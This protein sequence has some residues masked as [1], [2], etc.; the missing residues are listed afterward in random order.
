MYVRRIEE[1]TMTPAFAK[2]QID[3]FEAI[4]A[5]YEK[6]CEGERLL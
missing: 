3:I 5:D 6:L 1:G 2:E 4:A